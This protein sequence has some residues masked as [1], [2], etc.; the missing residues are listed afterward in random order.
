MYHLK[1]FKYIKIHPFKVYNSMVFNIFRVVQPLPQ[2]KFS[3]FYY[4]QKFLYPF[5]VTHLSPIISRQPPICVLFLWICLI[6]TFHINGI[7]QYMSF[8]VGL[9]SF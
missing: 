6:W 3:T 7:I 9:V 8:C 2:S 1:S 4:P 5:V